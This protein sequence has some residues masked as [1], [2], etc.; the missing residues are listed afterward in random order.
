MNNTIIINNE[1]SIG[2]VKKR[3]TR[4]VKLI[5]NVSFENRNNFL[6]SNYSI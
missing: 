6:N 1:Y 4:D 5:E 3:K 2:K